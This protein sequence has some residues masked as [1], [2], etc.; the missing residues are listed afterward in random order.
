MAYAANY[1][2]KIIDQYSKPLERISKANNRFRTSISHL[3]NRTERMQ[4]ALDKSVLSMQR[5][6]K[7]AAGAAIPTRKFARATQDINNHSMMLMSRAASMG[8]SFKSAGQ[9]MSV[10]LTLPIVGLGIAAGKTAVD[11]QSAFT[12]VRKTVN[13]TEAQFNV[14]RK[15][16]EN[17]S[18][19]IPVSAT[20]LMAIG[21]SAGQLGIRTKSI[22]SFSKTI[23][24]LGATTNLSGEEGATQLARFANIT[25]MSQDNFDR[26]G[27]TIVHLGNNLATTEA[28]IVSM[29]MRLAGAGNLIGLTESQI[30]SISGTLTSLG[31]N[32]EAGGTAFSKVMFKTN[33][34]VQKGGPMLELFSKIAGESAASF[35]KTFKEDA[36]S[37]ILSFVKGL[38]RMQ[39]EGK[40]VSKILEALE[41]NDIRVKDALLR[42]SGSGDLFRKSMELGNK[43]WKENN[44]LTKEAQLRFST[45]ASQLTMA[46]NKLKLIANEMGKIIIP[47]FIDFVNYAMPVLRWFS[48]LN[49]LIKK[50]IVI[51]SGVVAVIGPLLVVVG[52]LSA[53][54]AAI[55]VP[56]VIA[57]AA[58]AAIV[59]WIGAWVAVLVT[60]WRKSD[61]FRESIANL[62][63]A[64]SPLTNIVK[65]LFVWIGQKLGGAFSGS[66]DTIKTWADIASVYIN[67]VAAVIK[68]LIDWI[69]F[70][71]KIWKQVFTGKFMEAFKTIKGG[72]TFLLE[73]VGLVDKGADTEGIGRMQAIEK[74]AA[75]AQDNKLEVSG[76][77]GVSAAPGARIDRANINLNTGYNNLAT[78]GL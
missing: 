19:E 52:A 13:A 51:L 45:W 24:M 27:S 20:A 78:V 4:N 61:K 40:N 25:Q 47:I 42:A 10:G 16:F 59:A 73:K 28:E 58:V 71:G 18:T 68:T 15:Q 1:I 41:F 69:M 48:S 57:I 72:V 49:P 21:E 30:M 32:A 43:A 44:A 35:K 53:A 5:F 37:G 55:S 38:G 76:S 6:G 64:F 33:D 54:I 12:G 56:V 74:A 67:A 29:G 70:V 22:T 23:A 14:M 3:T 39:K 7:V 50:T 77:I 65:S 8:D 62:V 63:N 34:A 9:Q 11:F 36:A 60:A 75:R 31:I 66:G 2:Y 46:W 26:L 17:M